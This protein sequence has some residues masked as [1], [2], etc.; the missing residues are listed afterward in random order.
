MSTG[1]QRAIDSGASHVA[2]S[3]ETPMRG[4][5]GELSPVPCCIV[6]QEAARSLWNRLLCA[7]Y[8]SGEQGGLFID[9]INRMSNPWYCERIADKLPRRSPAAALRG[10]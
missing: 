10:V 2:G 3:A 6:R 8:D 5:P 9:R 1:R 7:G 4:R